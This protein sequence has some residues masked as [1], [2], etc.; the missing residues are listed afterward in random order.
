M[1]SAASTWSTSCRPLRDT[2]ALLDALEAG[3]LD[4]DLTA[5]IER[6]N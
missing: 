1:E 2:T 6:I 4:D 5:V 3:R